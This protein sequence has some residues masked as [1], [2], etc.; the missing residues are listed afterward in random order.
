MTAVRKAGRVAAALITLAIALSGCAKAAPEP[1]PTLEP[2]S[3][4]AGGAK[5]KLLELFF[6][7][8]R[9][10]AK[11]FFPFTDLPGAKDAAAA[12]NPLGDL[13]L[14][15][16]IYSIAAPAPKLLEFENAGDDEAMRTA[17]VTFSYELEG[18]KFREEGLLL[19]LPPGS[20]DDTVNLTID[21]EVEDVGF[22]V[23]GTREL[24]QGTTYAIFGIDVTQAFTAALAPGGSGRVPALGASY[25]IEV[26]VPGDSLAPRM[27]ELK[28]SSFYAAEPAGQSWAEFAAELGGS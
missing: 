5:A 6:Y 23:S 12:T 2:T 27:F 16:E 22:D 18:K 14:W 10:N 13:L 15:S 20:S 19:R 17:E 21:L 26:T 28:P 9:G 7:L 8:D 11:L 1:I 4:L 24:P 3:E 25:P